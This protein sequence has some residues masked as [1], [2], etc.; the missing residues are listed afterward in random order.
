[1]KK[2]VHIDSDSILVE[3]LLQKD[4]MAFNDLYERYSGPLY[5]SILKITSDRVLAEDILQEAFV[6]IWQNLH[7][8]NSEKGTL[9]S[10]I[11]R[12]VRN[13]ALDKVRLKYNN[14]EIQTDDHVV[15]INSTSSKTSI[16]EDGVGLDHIVNSL[17]P[18]E[19]TLID[20]AYF[21]GF[22]QVEIADKLQI[23]LG[24]VKTRTRKALKHLRKIFE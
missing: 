2:N 23:P 9:F 16:N 8:F 4:E 12:I 21:G 5:G 13:T 3:R 22:T 18:S 1:M 19:K 15:L 17:E 20:L 10:W 6:K 7:T 24:T 11:F 14:V